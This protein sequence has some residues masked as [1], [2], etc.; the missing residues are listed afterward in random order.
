MTQERQNNGTTKPLP[1][2]W[3]L[4]RD[5]TG[6]EPKQQTNCHSSLHANNTHAH[7]HTDTHTHIHT[8]I[9]THTHVEARFWTLER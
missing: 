2:L 8:H 1:E 7:T 6:D 4:T 9:Y 5:P 3:L